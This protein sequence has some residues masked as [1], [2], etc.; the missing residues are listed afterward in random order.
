MAAPRLSSPSIGPPVVYCM[1]L[2]VRGKMAQWSEREVA[3]RKALG[4]N[5]TSIFRLSL[6]R[7]GQ[8]GNIPALVLPSGDRTVR[9]RKGATRKTTVCYPHT[10][11][12]HGKSYRL[13]DCGNPDDRYGAVQKPKY[14]SAMMAW[15]YHTQLDGTLATIFFR[16]STATSRPLE[17][18]VATTKTDFSPGPKRIVRNR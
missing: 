11:S 7:F 16:I 2:Y 15:H 13:S 18:V 14:V 10:S 17:P 9:Y 6:S 3:D 4:S 5:P 1:L 12:C 8:P